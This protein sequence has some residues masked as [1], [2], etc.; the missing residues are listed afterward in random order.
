M[1]NKFDELTKGLVQSVTRRQALR[2]FGVGLAG[3]ALAMLGFANRAEAGG[4][5]DGGS[6]GPNK[7]FTV[8]KQ[9]CQRSGIS[10][11]LCS[12]M[13]KRTCNIA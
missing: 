9:S 8:C 5:H 12:D 11:K 3:V 6:A 2:R 13:C 7:C 4:A 1:Q 10:A